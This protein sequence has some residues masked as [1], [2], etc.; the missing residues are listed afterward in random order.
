MTTRNAT[1]PVAQAT[2]S[3]PRGR[4]GA[5]SVVRRSDGKGWRVKWTDLAGKRWDKYAPTEE[6]GHRLLRQALAGRDVGAPVIGRKHTVRSW[7][8]HW[9]PTHEVRLAPRSRLSYARTVELWSAAPFGSIRLVELRPEHVERRLADWARE[10]V[11]PSTLRTRMSI[12]RT[13]LEAAYRGRHIARNEARIAPMPQLGDRTVAPPSGDD[14]VALRGVID[15]HP[16]EAAFRLAL[17]AGLRSGEVSALQWRH[18]DLADGYV[19]V[20]GSL[21]QAT[22]TVGTT[23]GKRTRHLPVDPAVVRALQALR[24]TRYG[25]GVRSVPTAWVF[26]DPNHPARPLSSAQ[27]LRAWH[28]ACD[29]AKVRR[30][31]FHDL[32]HAFATEVLGRQVLPMALLSGYLGHSSITITVDTYGHLELRRPGLSS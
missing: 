28:L 25:V 2:S 13:A 15:G 29:Q 17:D 4:R 32:R 1:G 14:L 10:G 9:Y 5:G 31:R 26:Q 22:Q 7:L 20:A 8:A 24:D 19:D 11:A 3:R 18:V 16:L 27:L 6:A 23:K 12:L 30:Y 21:V